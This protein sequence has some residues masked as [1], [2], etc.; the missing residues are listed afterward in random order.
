MLAIID[1]GAVPIYP[2]VQNVVE[3]LY[4]LLNLSKP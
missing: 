3:N 1:I 4:P 2:K